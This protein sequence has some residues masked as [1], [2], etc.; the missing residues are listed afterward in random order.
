MGSSSPQNL[1]NALSIKTVKTQPK[2]AGEKIR[3]MGW[4]QQ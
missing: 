1:A 4:D 3:R 2:E